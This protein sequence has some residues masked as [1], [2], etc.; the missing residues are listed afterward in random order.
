MPGLV[1]IEQGEQLTDGGGVAEIVGGAGGQRPGPA[2]E[3]VADPEGVGMGEDGPGVTERGGGWRRA[4]AVKASAR[5]TSP[6]SCGV[7]LARRSARPASR[8]WAAAMSPRSAASQALVAGEDLVVGQRVGVGGLGELGAG[9]VPV[10]EHQQRHGQVD[11]RSGQAVPDAG[12]ARVPGGGPG[13]FGRRRG[14]VPARS[15]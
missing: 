3:F 15:V 11:G 14:S 5:P 13:G 1:V 10:A 2:Q 6:W 12:P 7:S 8:A 4:A 9:G